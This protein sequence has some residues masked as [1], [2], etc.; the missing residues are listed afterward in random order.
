VQCLSR[1]VRRVGNQQADGNFNRAVIDAM[2]EP[3]H[4]A[5]QHQTDDHADAHQ[6]RKASERRKNGGIFSGNHHRSCEL[7]GEQ[8]GGIVYQALAF[9]DVH[10][11]LREADAFGNP[12]RDRIGKSAQ[13]A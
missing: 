7:K 3:F 9:E 10:N 1:Q 13:R 4:N 2:F 5:A 11:P 6:I 12:G 8:A